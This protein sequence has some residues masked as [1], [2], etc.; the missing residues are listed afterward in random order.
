MRTAYLILA[1]RYPNQLLRLI[2][3]LDAEGNTFLIHLDKR[4]DPTSFD[5][6]QRETKGK[7]NIFFIR[8]FTCYWAGYGIIQA[9][10]EGI[11]EV[12]RRKIVFDYLTL[13]SGQDYP[14][15]PKSFIRNYQKENEGLSFVNHYPFPFE[16]WNAD[17]G[18]WDRVEKWFIIRNN[19]FAFPK[20]NQF[21]NKLSN[22]IWNRTF[23]RL[24]IKRKFP[25]GLQPYGGA[26]FWSL[27]YKHAKILCDY[28]IKNPQYVSFFRYVFVPDEILVQTLVGNLINPQ[29]I[30]NNTQTYL[31][32]YRKG[33]VLIMDD[34][35]NIKNTS[36]LYAR[37]FDDTVDSQIIKAIDEEILFKS[38][39][40]QFSTTS[41]ML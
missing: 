26:Q 6:I 38:E 28:I 33:A 12:F 5:L 41:K 19:I 23:A 40:N 39:A 35:E 36:H 10:C 29:E 7:S 34:L 22:A 21:K 13:L 25:N 17:N 8:R 14:I 37:K 31:E 2:D 11:K 9:T 4:M 20:A 18:G 16:E 24:P 1:H 27:H 32:W 30:I 3:R 15:K